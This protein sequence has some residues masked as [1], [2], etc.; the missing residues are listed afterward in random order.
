METPFGGAASLPTPDYYIAP[1]NKK[2]YIGDGVPIHIFSK[3]ELFKGLD[4]A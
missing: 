1:I 3:S 4:I 2:G